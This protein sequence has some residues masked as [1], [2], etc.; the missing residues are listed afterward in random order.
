[1]EVL[2]LAEQHYWLI[3]GVVLGI[4]LIGLNQPAAAGVIIIS[5]FALDTL[6]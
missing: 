4:L 1:M 2:R 6:R 3:A 5:G